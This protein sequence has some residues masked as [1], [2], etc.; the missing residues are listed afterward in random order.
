MPEFGI[1]ANWPPRAHFME[2]GPIRH[3]EILASKMGGRRMQVLGLIAV[4]KPIKQIAAE[5][6]ISVS[7]V[8]Q[9]IKAL[10]QQFGA[11]SL[12]DLWRVH[13]ELAEAG[14]FPDCI[15]SACT[16]SQLP[17]TPL[18]PEMASQEFGS[19][20]TTFHE[21]LAFRVDAPWENWTEQG[22]FQGVLNGSNAAWVRSALIVAIALGLFVLI[23]IGLGVA[24]G[25]TSVLDA[26]A[27][28]QRTD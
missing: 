16:K 11:N 24:Q 27:I 4:R 20:V 5:L 25:V 13:N 8:N 19:P 6:G 21:P 23:L 22:G 14:V 15:K 2:H 10:K 18:Q 1:S 7:A 3:D 9:H 17:Q 26:A 12:A 28:P